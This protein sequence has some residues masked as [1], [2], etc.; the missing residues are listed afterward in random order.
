MS[1]PLPDPIECTAC[2]GEGGENLFE[3]CTTCEGAGVLIPCAQC[4][5]AHVV[6]L[7]GTCATKAE[8]IPA[9]E[10]VY[11]RACGTYTCESANRAGGIIEV[12]ELGVGP[13]PVIEFESEPIPATEPV[14]CRACG[15]YTCESANR[16]GAAPDPIERVAPRDFFDPTARAV[17]YLD[18]DEV[19]NARA[20]LGQVSL[21]RLR[22]LGEH[23]DRLSMICFELASAANHA[24]DDSVDPA[25]FR[26][27][28]DD[29]GIIEHPGAPVV[30]PAPVIEFEVDD[31][32]ELGAADT[33]ERNLP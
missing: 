15:T 26:S 28:P 21:V 9:T 27:G 18:L 2:A 20:V 19:D 7:G 16:A 12:A 31:L 22:R 11:C 29:E 24:A 17:T 25:S 10:P 4:G 23:Y 6:D 13:A 14:Y 3:R 30:R 8:P 32:D 5:G 1:Q 33:A